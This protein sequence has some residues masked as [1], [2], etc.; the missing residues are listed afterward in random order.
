M[1]QTS[2]IPFAYQPIALVFL[3]NKLSRRKARDLIVPNFAAYLT[4]CRYRHLEIGVAS[5]GEDV[6]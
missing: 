5:R 1:C 3:R 4:H 6:I 2:V